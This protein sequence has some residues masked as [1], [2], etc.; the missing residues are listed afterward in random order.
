MTSE[1]LQQV[2]LLDPVSDT[3]RIADVLLVDGVIQAIADPLS[4]Y[5]AETEVRDCR[6]LVLAIPAASC[7]CGRFYSPCHTAGHQPSDRQSRQHHV[8]TKPQPQ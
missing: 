4:D 7:R 1:L 5:P 6:G 8:D 2:R 3:D